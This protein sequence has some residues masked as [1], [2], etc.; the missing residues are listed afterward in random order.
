MPVE[1]YDKDEF[2]RISERAIRCTIKRLGDYVKIKLKTKRRL[3][4][5]KVKAEEAK[6]LISKLKIKCTEL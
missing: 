3:Y 1:I 6:E 4:T 5:I 2:V